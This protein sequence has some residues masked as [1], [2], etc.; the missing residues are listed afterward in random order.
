M[1]EPLISS[2][3]T[4][5]HSIWAAWPRS[6]WMRWSNGLSEP[7]AA[8]VERA[9]VTSDACKRRSASNRPA[10]AQ[11]AENCVPLRRASPSLGPSASSGERPASARASAAGLRPPGVMTSPIPIR[12]Q[13]IW[14]SGA[15]SPEAPTEPCSGTTGRMSRASIA[16]SSA[17]VSSRTPEAP[18]ARLASFSAI[19]IRVRA[20]SSGSPTPAEWESTILRCRVSSCSGGM[21]TEA[22]FPKPVLTP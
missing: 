18:R 20:G 19:I 1:A 16:S 13:V 17:T 4:A 12:A 5:A 7:R 15:R 8:S 10:S 9:D 6:A 11:A 22:S 14:A 3:R 2:R 21:R